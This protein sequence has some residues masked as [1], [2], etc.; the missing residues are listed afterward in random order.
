MIYTRSSFYY[1]HTVD[2]NNNVIVFNEGSGDIEATMRFG[3]YSLT[4]YSVEVARAMNSISLNSY[5][6]AVDRATRVL[7]I[8]GTSNFSFDP[9]AAGAGN[10]AFPL[11]GY[12]VAKTG[13]NSYAGDEGSGSE[14]RPQFYLQNFVDFDKNKE[15]L[16]GTV[17]ESA[18]GKA[19]VVSF[20]L[21]R[22][23]ECSVDFIN[24]FPRNAG[25]IVEE[26]LTGEADA[27]DF[28]DYLVSK[29]QLEFMPD[30]DTPSSYTKVF[31]EST[32]LSRDGVGY[33]LYE[34]TNRGVNDFFTTQTLKFREVE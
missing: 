21:A 27:I 19:E 31:L 29:G 14:Y 17:K 10:S 11:M 30:R 33:R 25:S 1:G 23:M 16:Q 18:S 20:G 5:V 34:Y 24:D 3:K 22:F 32:A 12:T 28:M 7:T 8:S 13:S 26:N 4:D 2:Q 15:Y 9:V 6:V